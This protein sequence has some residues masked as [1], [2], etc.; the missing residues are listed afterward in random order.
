MQ[1]QYGV[2]TQHTIIVL[3]QNVVDL[4]DGLAEILMHCLRR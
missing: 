3:D 4:K 2:T 1:N